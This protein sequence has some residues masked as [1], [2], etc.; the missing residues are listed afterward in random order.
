MIPYYGILFLI[1]VYYSL[2][3][4]IIPYYGI[5]FLTMVYYS[6]LWYIIPYYGNAGFLS[7]TVGPMVTWKLEASKKANTHRRWFFFGV[8]GL[9]GF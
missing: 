9:W 7:S 1:M 6:L 2:L 8:S 4:Y 5:L 3:W